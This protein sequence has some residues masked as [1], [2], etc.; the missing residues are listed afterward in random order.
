MRPISTLA[1]AISAVTVFGGAAY[2]ESTM[3]SGDLIKEMHPD[4]ASQGD[5]QTGRSAAGGEG[6]SIGDAAEEDASDAG[7]RNE[8][9]LQQAPRTA[10]DADL[11]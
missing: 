11:Q 2:A 8:E 6:P 1:L 7:G 10:P 3:S 4:A 9:F 5:L